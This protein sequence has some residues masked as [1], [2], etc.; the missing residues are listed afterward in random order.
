MTCHHRRNATPAAGVTVYAV[1]DQPPP[2]WPVLNV[3]H[4]GVYDAATGAITR[5]PV[6]EYGAAADDL[7]RLLRT[8]YGD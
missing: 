2:T 4:A 6:I 3:S 8:L 1:E 5:L 7:D